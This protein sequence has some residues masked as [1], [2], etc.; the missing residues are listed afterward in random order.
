[1]RKILNEYIGGLK[2]QWPKYRVTIMCDGWTSPTRQSIINFMVYCDGIT[3][4]LKSVEASKVI[5]GYKYICASLE[6]VI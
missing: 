6:D 4:F 1:M 5:K 2:K 3:V